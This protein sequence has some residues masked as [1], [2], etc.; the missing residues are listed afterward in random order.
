MKLEQKKSSKQPE[1]AGGPS[2]ETT[3]QTPV[4][5]HTNSGVDQDGFKIEIKRKGSMH[6]RDNIIRKMSDA[7][8]KVPKNAP[9][10]AP[11]VFD[12]SIYG[13]ELYPPIDHHV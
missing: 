1:S 4:L 8:Y 11:E 9:K 10:K 13:N 5:S 2:K 7:E 12:E 6:G 3:M